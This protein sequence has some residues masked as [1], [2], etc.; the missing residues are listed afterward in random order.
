MSDVL[1][2]L[3]PRLGERLRLVGRTERRDVEAW[4]LFQRAERLHQ[5]IMA[6][7]DPEVE[8]HLAREADSLLEEARR[9]DPDWIEPPLAQTRVMLA[10]SDSTAEDF[11]EAVR[12][13][14]AVP[15]S[16]SPPL[17]S[18]RGQLRADLAERAS[19][20]LTAARE[21]AA[22]ERD[23][24][25]A[26]ANDPDLARAWIALADQLYH[27]LWDLP[28][29]RRAAQTA[30]REDPFLLEE[31]TGDVRHDNESRH[32]A[33]PYRSGGTTSRRSRCASTSARAR[34]IGRSRFSAYSGS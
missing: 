6:V 31:V 7:D 33:E 15:E 18:L 29:A 28:E 32:A 20:S 17:L 22:A 13:I 14:E 16:D 4:D 9:L 30:W 2:Q 12:R 24:R 23:L 10:A 1:S 34:Q 3:R 25:T 26:V 5:Q 8:L 21:I 11:R 27:D 19:D